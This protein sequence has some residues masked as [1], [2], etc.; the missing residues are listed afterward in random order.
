MQD[1]PSQ[2]AGIEEAGGVAE[3][4]DLTGTEVDEIVGGVGGV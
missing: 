1:P 2:G 3:D 4:L